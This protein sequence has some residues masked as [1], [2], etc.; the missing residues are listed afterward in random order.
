MSGAATSGK[1]WA[2]SRFRRAVV[3][4][5]LFGLTPLP[6][7]AAER[8]R[9]RFPPLSPDESVKLITL[10]PGYRATV[11]AAE[12]MIQEP[13]R[14][15][16][17]GNGA[18]YV[19]EMNSY[20]QDVS[21]TGTKT[22]R[23][24][25]IKRLVDTDGDGRMD[26]VT[27]YADELLLPRMIL[28]LD[29]RILV[30]ETDDTTLWSYRDLDDDGVADEKRIAYQGNKALASVEHQDS[31][32]T[33]AMDN[34]LYTAQ[35]GLRY[36]LIDGKWVGERVASEF[37]QWGLGMDDTGTLFFSMNSIPGRSFQQHWYYWNLIGER[38]NWERFE[39]PSLG[40]DTDE[41][42]QR[43][44]RLFPIGGRAEEPRN[45]WTSGCGLSIYR[46]DVL[47]ADFRG[48]MLLCEPCGQMVRRAKVIR[49]DGH[50]TLR[51]GHEGKEFFASGDFYSRPVSTH[52][53]PD[54]C[55]YIVDMYRGMIQDA[56]WVSEAFRERIISM[57][58]DQVKNR[59][60]IYRISHD[61]GMPGPA[62][63]LLDAKPEELVPHLAHANGW[64]RDNAQKLLILRADARVIP[65]VRKMAASHLNPLARLH[66]L[67]TLE[68]LQALDRGLLSSCVRDAD[69]RVRAAAIRLHEPWV[70]RGDATAVAALEFMARDADPEVR[71]QLILT[72]GWSTSVR[73][74]DIIQQI[75]AADPASKIILLATL[76][77][78][79]GREDLPLVRHIRDGSLFRD[80]TNHT[81]RVATEERWTAGLKSWKSPLLASSQLSPGDV[82]LID[83]GRTIYDQICI[84]C[85]GADGRGLQPPGG[86][87]LAP[88][89]AGSDIVRGPKEAL[90][91]VMLH[92]LTG[93]VNGKRYEGGQMAP[94]GAEN[95]D[96]W[97]AAVLSYV[98]HEWDNGASMIRPASVTTLRA[99]TLS[100]ARPWTQEE[101]AQFAA[102]RLINGGNWKAA[103]V[104][105]TPENAIDGV[106]DDSH[107][108]AWHGINNP[109]CW[110]SIDLGHSHLLTHLV[111]ESADPFCYPRGFKV[112]VSNDGEVWSEP[113]ATGY[114]EGAL[115]MASFEPV[116][117]RHIRVTQTG[118]KIERW[119][120][121]ELH[122]HGWPM[123]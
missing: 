16:W 54:G 69:A 38:K 95:N 24:G 20:M 19:L 48:D 97:T 7:A 71:R 78:L 98:R 109:G 31:G 47:P 119:L 121:S 123:R 100:R 58:M 59:G 49:T 34:W 39:R 103:A 27:I 102:P 108:H 81:I 17:D 2:G 70:K 28:P 30:Q 66:A 3:L 32:L 36:R 29:E 77:A 53:G 89:L 112:E 43:T 85:H 87:P 116:E 65:A 8:A 60:R 74:V 52:T 63:R 22:N 110:L 72:L 90:G 115:T 80:I 46:G 57:G 111:M 37:N 42:F 44:Y 76:T 64:W 45:T 40:R 12:P 5:A 93:P 83:Q 117:A 122:I 84:A 10:P 73:A 88:P 1:H 21:G 107:Q 33:W 11:V 91:R 61:A 55:L 25:R 62:P 67:W 75:A 13:V 114:G 68:G 92:G 51:N 106:M 41:A 23:N 120:V 9:P 101:L 15:A 86:L 96:A 79:H 104:G 94:L 4:A 113:V 50:I 56:P 35:G 118:N 26:L 14:I 18:M 82:K 6:V 105:H 99:K